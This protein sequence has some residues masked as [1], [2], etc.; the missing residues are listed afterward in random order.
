MQALDA[1]AVGLGT[2][3]LGGGRQKKGDPIGRAV[4]VVLAAKVGSEVATGE[5]LCAVHAASHA[6]AEAVIARL[7][8]AYIILPVPAAP[9]PI[10]LD[11][12]TG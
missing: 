11:R 8:G 4:G 10:V 9:L 12:V 7:Q 6:A 1:R 3:E 5:P 2:V